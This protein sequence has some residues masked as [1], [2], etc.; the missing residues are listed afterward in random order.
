MDAL[1]AALCSPW[2]ARRRRLQKAQ[3]PRRLA[4]SERASG[5]IRETAYLAATRR[6]VRLAA[7]FGVAAYPDDARDLEGLLALADQALFAVKRSGRNGIAAAGERDREAPARE[8][9]LT[10]G[11]RRGDPR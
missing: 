3:I 8:I 9:A 7:S 11:R 1:V 10:V 4:R 6:P 5:R 2:E